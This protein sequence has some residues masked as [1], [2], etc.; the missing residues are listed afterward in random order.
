MIFEH[1]EQPHWRDHDGRLMYGVGGVDLW[2]YGLVGDANGDNTHW[3]YIAGLPIGLQ[4]VSSVSSRTGEYALAGTWGG[5]IFRVNPAEDLDVVEQTVAPLGGKEDDDGK[6][7]HRIVIA[8]D[9]LAFASFNNT[10]GSGG[11]A[12]KW[13]G[14]SW[15]AVPAGFPN[16]FIYAMEIDVVDGDPV[17]YLATDASVYA[18]GDEGKSWQ[19][20]SSGLPKRPHCSDLRLV[21]DGDGTHLYLSTFGRSLWR[22]DLLT[23]IYV[24]PR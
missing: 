2:V 23:A 7:V 15:Q 10:D 3:S 14:N 20:V 18:S 22:G 16:E 6:V 12:L 8:T 13:D 5:R 24:R 19:D 11:T 21:Q 17:V 1:V 4:T 9:S